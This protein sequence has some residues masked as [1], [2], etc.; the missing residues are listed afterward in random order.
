[1]NKLAVRE[2]L[3]S[4]IIETK[5]LIASGTATIE[6]LQTAQ[7]V[8]KDNDITF[9]LSP[10][11][12]AS[13]EANQKLREIIVKGLQDSTVASIDNSGNATF[14][15]TLS[16]KE[17][18]ISGELTAESISAKTV[19]S[20]NIRAIEER[21]S[22]LSTR[23]DYGSEIGNIQQLL[24]DIK[25]Q[26]MPQVSNYQN[27]FN[28]ITVTGTSNLY[29]LTV[30]NS[31]VAGNMLFENSS[32]L[33]LSWE[34]KLNALSSID[35]LDG[36][37]TIARDGTLTTRG[38]VVAQGGLATNQI[39][40]INENNNLD[41]VLSSSDT[42]EV[43]PSGSLNIKNNLLQTVAS[44]DSSGSAYFAKGISVDKYATD[45]STISIISATDNLTRN[46]IFAPAIETADE[47]A[48]TGIL[49]NGTNEVILYN[50]AIADSSLIYITATSA[51]GNKSLYIANKEFCNDPTNYSCKKYFKVAI[52]QSIPDDIKFNWWIL[53]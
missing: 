51:T 18:S 12:N 28:D 32:V 22:N 25:D 19:E 52:D 23:R 16:A 21:I 49:P 4:P 44:I 13:S 17:A 45:S 9:D 2:K 43:S 37:V 38:K 48:G 11:D 36:A 34:L 30:T 27:L 1:M 53:N 3:V 5:D 40:P 50:N 35:L 46:G 15:G 31:F 6:K 14:S 29:D 8:P 42:N 7:I 39:R 33:S 47:P 26:P 10:P 41:I 24:N 20:E